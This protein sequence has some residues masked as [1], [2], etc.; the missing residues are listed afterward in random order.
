MPVGAAANDIGMLTQKQVKVN[1]IRILVGSA[2]KIN[3]HE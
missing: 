2:R 3:N 1:L